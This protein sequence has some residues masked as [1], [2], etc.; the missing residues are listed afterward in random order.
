MGTRTRHMAAAPAGAQLPRLPQGADL[1][2]ES[3]RE[4]GERLFLNIIVGFNVLVFAAVGALV[5]AVPPMALVLMFVGGFL[6]FVTWVST[7]LLLA[8]CEGHGVRVSP[9]QYPQVYD[10]VR[11]AAG[12]LK[13]RMPT[14][15]VLPGAGLVE[16]LVAKYFTRK[17]FIIL[18]S[19]LMDALIEGGT[20]RELLMLLGRQLGHIKAGHFRF[21]F[22]KEVIG[23]FLPFV[24]QAYSRRCHVTADR[25]GMMVAG[26]CYAAEQALLL[27]TVGPKLAPHTNVEEIE[28]QADELHDRFWTRL[29]RWISFYP[30]L[31]DRIHFL[32]EFA[33][34]VDDLRAGE[35]GST[36]I[37]ALPIR[38]MRLQ[39][40][41]VMIVHGHDHQA[42]LELKDFL[43]VTYPFIEPVV[44][45]LET[46]GTSSMPE[47][48]ERLAAQARGAI[49]VLTPD[50]I[51]SSVRSIATSSARA[52]QNVVLEIGYFWAHLGRGRC[53]LLSHGEIE[54][55][56]DLAGVDCLP[57]ARSP[58]EQFES[59][60]EFITK[61]ESL[62]SGVP[63]EAVR[64]RSV[65]SASP[66]SRVTSAPAVEPSIGRIY[67]ALC[68]NGND[69]DSRFCEEC[70]RPLAV[71]ARPA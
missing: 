6:W 59:V 18:T 58:R 26:E 45:A 4:R 41:P 70:G 47:K 51:G 31:I 17:G 20:S 29:Q 28:R 25:I 60:R 9:N 56:S 5:L 24:A 2:I 21:W 61:L 40:L 16:I 38:H 11:E 15:I 64:R 34:T 67:C 37:G 42:L 43:R 32:R 53:L 65:R 30:Y 33:A 55:P 48:F 13:I 54:I 8:S 68:G 35:G 19:D 3:L 63:V 66:D 69:P 1:D 22:F 10:V 62:E 50:D 52:R 23:G 7:K 36:S 44:M 27:L 12:L 39:T 57:Y 71:A 46:L 14:I 49:A